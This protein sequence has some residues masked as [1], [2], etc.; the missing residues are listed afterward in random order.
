MEEEEAWKKRMEEGEEKRAVLRGFLGEPRDN[1]N[2]ALQGA[3]EG[4]H[5]SN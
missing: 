1:E 5:E 3:H 2:V 4:V